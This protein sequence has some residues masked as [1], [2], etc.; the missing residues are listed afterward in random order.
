MA[1]PGVG[2]ARFALVGAA[3]FTR[4][5]RARKWPADFPSSSWVGVSGGARVACL[6][7]GGAGS[8][9]RRGPYDAGHLA[10]AGLTPVTASPGS[11]SAVPSLGKLT[12]SS[13][14]FANKRGI[15]LGR[16]STKFH[17]ALY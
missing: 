1:G 5:Q 2:P 10:A 6:R 7:A 15:Y 17:V 9:S 16:R 11:R 3:A 14:Q 13:S 4:K 12:T 8:G